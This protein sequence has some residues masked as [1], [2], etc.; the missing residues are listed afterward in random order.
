G[1]RQQGH[2]RTWCRRFFSSLPGLTWQSIPLPTSPASGGGRE[3][4]GPAVKPAGDN[5]R[6]RGIAFAR[7]NAR[8]RARPPA[9]AAWR[10]D[11][12]KRRSD[13]RR[14]SPPSVA[15]PPGSPAPQG[16]GEESLPR[17][18]PKGGA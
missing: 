1:G 18:A 5:S 4:D 11:R 9:V 13:S 15:L 10:A 2:D 7:T 17:R 6:P 14:T 8:N 16:G 12:Q 3:A